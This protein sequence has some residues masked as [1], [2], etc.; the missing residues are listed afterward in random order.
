MVGKALGGD[1]EAI[2]S[3]F[4]VLDLQVIR[5]ED[6][7]EKFAKFLNMSA[8]HCVEPVFCRTG[9]HCDQHTVIVKM[10]Y[11]PFCACGKA[12]HTVLIWK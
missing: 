11:Q 5:G 3:R 4:A 8:G 12:E 2:Q 10:I 1:E 7:V 9:S 6:T